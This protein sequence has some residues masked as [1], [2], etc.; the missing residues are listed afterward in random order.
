MKTFRANKSFIPESVVNSNSRITA[1]VVVLPKT[2]YEI[3][4]T[5]QAFGI[6]IKVMSPTVADS[7]KIVTQQIYISPEEILQYGEVQNKLTLSDV[8]QILDNISFVKSCIDFNW[9]WEVVEIDGLSWNNVDNPKESIPVRGFLIN[10][11]FQRPDINTGIM[12]TGKGRRMWIEETASETSIVMTAWVCVELIIKH[13]TLE[14]FLYE[15][16]KILNPHKT[17]S[18]LA[19]PET[20]ENSK[21]FTI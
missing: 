4:D 19:Y 12:G 15:K 20:L 7:K 3:V 6:Y 13:E 16:A 14:S 10:T 18:Q 11:T 21:S 2:D 17:L 5:N 8:K 1:P 9:N